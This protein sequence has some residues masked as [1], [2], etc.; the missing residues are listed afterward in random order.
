MSGV[1]TKKFGRKKSLAGPASSPRTR[2]AP[3]RVL[4]REVGVGLAEAGLRE[5]VH[6]GGAGER[7]GQEHHVGVLLADCPDESTPESRPAWW[8]MSTRTSRTPAP[9]RTR[10]RRAAPSRA[11][12]SRG[13]EVDVVDVLVALGRVL[14]ILQRPVGAAVEP[15]GV[16]LQPRVVRGALDRAVER[17]LHAVV[18]CRP[19][20]RLEVL[21]GPD[22][23]LHGGV[24]ALLVADSPRASG[25]AR[26]RDGGVVATLAVGMADGMDRGR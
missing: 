5:G 11:P 21:E 14:R 18:G 22:R 26:L 7:L 23:R 20:E 10:R 13:R 24:A 12:P 6:P 1:L 25:L 2:A 19:H 15:V 8:G 9:P 4:P 17:D 16:V 3:R